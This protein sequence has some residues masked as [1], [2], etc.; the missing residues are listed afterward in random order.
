MTIS[1]AD[2][3]RLPTAS[4]DAEYRLAE[5]NSFRLAGQTWHQLGN[6]KLP[7]IVRVV[8]TPSGIIYAKNGKRPQT[9]AAAATTAELQAS[10]YWGS[11]SGVFLQ[12]PGVWWI[13]LDSATAQTVVVEDAISTPAILSAIGMPVVGGVSGLAAD[14]RD[15]DTSADVAKALYGLVGNNRMAVYDQGVSADFRFL[16]GA[17]LAGGSGIQGLS[18]ASYVGAT[19]VSFQTGIDT[20]A[21][22]LIRTAEG[23]AVSGYSGAATS[24]IALL[25]AAVGHARLAGGATIDTLDCDALTTPDT[26]ATTSTR[27]M[28]DTHA[29]LVGRDQIS[30]VLR[31]IEAQRNSATL[32]TQFG[33]NAAP[34]TGIAV[35]SRQ[36]WAPLC[37]SAT[38]AADSGVTLTLP[39][40]AASLRQHLVKVLITKFNAAVQA[41]AA[42]P[43]IVTTTNLVGSPS[44][45]FSQGSASSGANATGTIERVQIQP[46]H[47]IRAD[48]AATAVTFVA[49]ATT[50]VIWKITAWYYDA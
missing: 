9:A 8:G 5:I 46:S 48:A 31:Q 19:T 49:P 26:L 39:A 38:A 13:Y 32:T 1:V 17:I 23:R 29:L 42:V 2:P 50:G 45:D 47:V 21:G 11:N 15:G 28:L 30:A 20:T 41:A 14:V 12:T 7:T 43:L 3:S 16:G 36:R 37:V 40:P 22:T 24:L 10:C 34:Q 25:N 18:A 44:F 6:R 35:N 33:D 4:L 27:R